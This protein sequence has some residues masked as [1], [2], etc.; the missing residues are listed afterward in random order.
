MKILIKFT[1]INEYNIS[2]L[3]QKMTTKIYANLKIEKKT[4]NFEHRCWSLECDQCINLY[5]E[6]L[7]KYDEKSRDS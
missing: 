4:V 1:S 2:Q 3:K 7:S 6:N 5:L